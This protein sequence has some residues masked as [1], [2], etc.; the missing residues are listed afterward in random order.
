MK[1]KKINPS[2]FLFLGYGFGQGSFFVL[3]IA[4]RSFSDA[5]STGVMVLYVSLFSLCYQFADFGN[6]PYGVKCHNNNDR[7]AFLD[8]RIGRAL[9]SVPVVFFASYYFL[10]KDLLIEQSFLS[11]ICITIGGVIFS[12]CDLAYI[13][14]KGDYFQ[15]SIL[16]AIPW[17]FS[18]LLLWIT[19]GQKEININQA[20]VI[21][22][23]A[24]VMYFYYVNKKCS[25]II[26]SKFV[27]DWKGIL[28]PFAFLIPNI[29][30]QFWARWML[31]LIVSVSTITELGPF[32][33]VR[34][35]YTAICLMIGF[36]IRPK[37]SF[38]VK[39]FSENGEKI[40]F[41]SFVD[42][43]DTLKI[44][45]F[46]LFILLFF[47]ISSIYIPD[48]L[49]KWLPIL[50]GIPAW[51]VGMIFSSINQIM[52][53]P[54]C[55]SVI[56]TISMAVHVAVFFVFYKSS[57]VFAFV[58]ADYFRVTFVLIV[59]FFVMKHKSN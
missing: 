57:I 4:L 16:Q 53:P 33:L 34:S 35:A 47:N 14:S 30:G 17:V 9:I 19:F 55:F 59:T 31:F 56:E 37:L 42:F 41:S 45:F 54:R 44:L 51:G 7:L 48:D 23:I 38:L 24:S 20:C 18:S 29:V 26:S 43:L 50:F 2:V 21:W 22:L 27:Y 58:F 10:N 52:L 39:R 3:Q 15:L 1:I 6:N 36:L 46:L 13:E 5:V 11:I 32:T 25:N 12:L 40:S 28:T 8:Y 49:K